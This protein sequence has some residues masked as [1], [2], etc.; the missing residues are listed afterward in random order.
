MDLLRHCSDLAT[1][2]VITE[3][4]KEH[5]ER[6]HAAEARKLASMLQALKVGKPQASTEQPARVQLFMEV[7]QRSESLV[8]AEALRIKEVWRCAWQSC[9]S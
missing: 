4:A 9:R 2:V 7:K 3:T 1:T 6:I 8:H 5:A